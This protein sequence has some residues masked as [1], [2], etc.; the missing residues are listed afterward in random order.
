Q[1]PREQM[2]NLEL[3]QRYLMRPELQEIIPDPENPVDEA[4]LRRFMEAVVEDDKASLA[5]R[6]HI[7]E[8]Y[9]AVVGTTIPNAPDDIRPVQKQACVSNISIPDPAFR[10]IRTYAVDPSLSTR[11][12]TASINDVTLKVQWE[13]KLAPGPTGEYLAVVDKDA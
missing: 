8:R 2:F 7:A 1:P 11:L 4:T 3:T 13:K 6:K 10:R 9:S 5:L 12:E